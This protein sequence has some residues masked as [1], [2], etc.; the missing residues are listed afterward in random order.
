MKALLA[1]AV[2]ALLLVAGWLWRAAAP[3]PPERLAVSTALGGAADD[4]A[5]ARALAPRAFDFP[6]DHGQHPDFRNEWWYFTGN[7]ASADG[8]PFGFQLTLFRIALAAKAVAGE[9]AWRDRQVWMGHLA[10]SDIAGRQFHAFERFSRTG[11]GLAGAAD[12]AMDVHLEDWRIEQLDDAGRRFR[13]RAVVHSDDAGADA[14]HGIALTLDAE[15]PVVLNGEQGLSRK[16]AAPGNASYYYAIPRL[17]AEGRVTV[18]GS[19]HA[20][21]GRAWLDREWST[22]A[23][24]RD[25]L[26]WD[27][28]ALH[29]DD[30]SD[31]MLYRMRRADG[32]VDPFSAAT[33]TAADGSVTRL[34]SDAFSIEPDSWWQSPQSGVRYP[35]GWRIS[36]PSLQLEASITPRQTDQELNLT[37]TYW[38]GAVSVDGRRDGRA[39]TGLGYVELAGYEPAH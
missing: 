7:L 15:K 12:Q 30:G 26:G 22:S 10:I 20:V 9:S 16:S 6:A 34:G 5:W 11:P 4:P 14:H 29:L 1:T 38:E 21:S 36:V 24:G 28:F 3:P 32:S 31:L 35:A 19:S 27:W 23:L 8:R 2:L 13:L 33:H 39:L 18:D 37:V 17:R 25:Q